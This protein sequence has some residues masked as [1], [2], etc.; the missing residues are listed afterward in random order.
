MKE[1]HITILC[2][3]MISFIMMFYPHEAFSDQD[4]EKF[5]VSGPTMYISTDNGKYIP[6]Q[7]IV[8]KGV[9]YDEKA[10]PYNGKVS[11]EAKDGEKILYLGSINVKNGTFR[12]AA[13]TLENESPEITI[14]ATTGKSIVEQS[15]TIVQITDFLKTKVG[16]GVLATVIF[17]GGVLALLYAQTKY[18]W[19]ISH[20]EPLRFALIT[21]ASLIPIIVFVAADVQL[22]VDGLMGLVI[23]ETEGDFSE[24]NIKDIVEG[25]ISDEDL[26]ERSLVTKSEWVINVGGHVRDGYSS[27][28]QIPVFVL[29]FGM[30]G[31]YLR[32][33]YKTAN[34]WLKRHIEYEIKR[35]GLTSQDQI[36]KAVND[37]LNRLTQ[38]GCFTPRIKRIIVNN[39]ME[40]LALVFLSPLL[41]VATYF[42][43]IQGGITV[44]KGMPAIA[45]V[46]WAA[47]LSTNELIGKLQVTARGIYDQVKETTTKDEKSN[48][49][50]LIL[51]MHKENISIQTIAKIT[52]LSEDIINKYIEES[53]EELEREE[54]QK[55]IDKEELKKKILE[56]RDKGKSN[57]DIAKKLDITEEEVSK[58]K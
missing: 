49:K 39:S 37:Q 29:I 43:L 5:P 8:V 27:G 46:C 28:I 41:A 14:T 58:T 25:R 11:L 6:G 13:I 18:T 21:L 55:K 36:P 47:G 30:L 45:V 35:E 15:K 40:D 2:I 53:K 32:F 31:G 52:E 12:H 50:D 3:I 44:E 17:I 20:V 26:Q 42:V 38:A 10:Q 56:L 33:L 57:A 16:A 48:K 9:A 24:I 22:G 54:K 19:K 1:R 4:E 51:R 34:G 7:I 23:K